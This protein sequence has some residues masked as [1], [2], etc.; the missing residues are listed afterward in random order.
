MKSSKAKASSGRASTIS[1]PR[2]ELTS[3]PTPGYTTKD[4]WRD[5][6]VKR[7]SGDGAEFERFEDLTRKLVNA[8]KPDAKS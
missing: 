3:T 5:V 2:S 7:P 8:P 6:A 4:F 1:I